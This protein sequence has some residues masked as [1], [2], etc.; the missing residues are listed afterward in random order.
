MTRRLLIDQKQ[1]Y[2]AAFGLIF[3]SAAIFWATARD[4]ETTTL[5]FMNYWRIKRGLEVAVV[6]TTRRMDGSVLARQ[7]IDWA[8]RAVINH[9]VD[10][11]DE[12]EGSVEVE[13]FSNRNLV[14]PYPAIMAIYETADG[15]SMVHSYGRIYSPMEVENGKTIE[16]GRES[17]FTLRD[18]PGVRSFC[19]FH[20]GYEIQP[21]Q[22]VKVRI[23][24]AAGDVRHADLPLGELRP[25][26]SVRLM[27]ANVFPELEAFL[28]GQPGN[29]ALEFVLARAF[30]RMLVGNETTD[31]RDRQV[32]HSNFDY[33]A[34]QT[35]MVEGARDAVMALAPM[36]G[37]RRSVIVYPDSEPG[38]Y[39]LELPAGVRPF[40]S[41]ERVEAPVDGIETLRVSRTDGPMPSRI[42]TAQGVEV[43]GGASLPIEC[44]L[45][46]MHQG[47]PG[48]HSH[49]MVLSARAGDRSTV[50]GTAME[51]LYGPARGGGTLSLH[52]PLSADA[53]SISLDA[54]AVA[55][56]LSGGDP[57]ALAEGAG[58]Q[59]GE[60]WF[61][62]YLNLDYPGW[63][64]FSAIETGSG[65]ATLEHAF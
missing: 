64:V 18:R 55:S 6:I 33:A 56:L 57:L 50:Y 16:R 8:G 14:I 43:R 39:Q 44:S 63:M 36:P 40:R 3:R 11:G 52:S 54:A 42:V 20:N 15:L 13:V 32:T 17:G 27:P 23:V 41:G 25:Y 2:A 51:S 62:A 65:A 31:G 12:T 10:L 19:V 53:V 24:N 30:T 5:S 59:P 1:N 22:T 49:W 9:L 48:K 61:W 7:A 58:F 28:G 46:V 29:A 34:H 21:A 47:R 35:D 4:H 37:R 60:D 26:Q 45:G 38:D